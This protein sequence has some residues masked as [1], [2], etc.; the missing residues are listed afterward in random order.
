MTAIDPALQKLKKYPAVKPETTDSII[1]MPAQSDDGFSVTLC[2][3][4]G[5]E[6]S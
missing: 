2:A 5:V 6:S 3:D 4:S 1:R